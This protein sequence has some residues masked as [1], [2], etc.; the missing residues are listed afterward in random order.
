MLVCVSEV[1]GY[2]LISF[3]S[4]NFESFSWILF[5]AA[6]INNTLS[7]FSKKNHEQVPEAVLFLFDWDRCLIILIEMF[8]LPVS[9]FLLALIKPNKPKANTDLTLR[10]LKTCR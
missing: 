5:Y 9:K 10:D 6:Y 8:K 3:L 1:F 7:K 4:S 2:M